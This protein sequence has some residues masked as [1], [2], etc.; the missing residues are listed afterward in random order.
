MNQ[1]VVSRLDLGFSNVL[2]KGTR[3]LHISEEGPSSF[4]MANANIAMSYSYV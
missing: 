2:L 3:P 4:E 1:R